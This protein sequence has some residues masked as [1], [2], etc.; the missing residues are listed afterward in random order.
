LP[1]AIDSGIRGDLMWGGITVRFGV[2]GLRAFPWLDEKQEVF[3]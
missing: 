3:G 1:P 2:E